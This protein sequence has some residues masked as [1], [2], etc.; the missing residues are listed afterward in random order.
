MN[1]RMEI[2]RQAGREEI[3]VYVNVGGNTVSVGSSREK[4]YIKRA[5]I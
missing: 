1:Q 4:D 2:Y 5:L 3:K